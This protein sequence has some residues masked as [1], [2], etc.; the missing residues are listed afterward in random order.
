MAFLQ[1][2]TIV[3]CRVL[4]SVSVS[5]FVAPRRLHAKKP[6][7]YTSEGCVVEKIK[8]KKGEKK[9]EKKEASGERERE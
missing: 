8:R 4:T 6:M 7:T 2:V 1:R 3:E 9:S 5:M